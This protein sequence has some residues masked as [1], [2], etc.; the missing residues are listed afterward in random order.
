VLDYRTRPLRSVL[1]M[2]ASNAK[3]I[4]KA[5]S[6]ACDAVIL[7]LEDA[8]APSEKDSARSR[9]VGAVQ[10]GGFGYRQVV[11]RINGLDTPW[12]AADIAALAD[13]Q[14]DAILAPKVS[15]AD[16]V[17]RYDALMAPFPARTHLWIM[18]E[19]AR[20]IFRIEEIADA[21]SNTRL[22]AFV[23]GTNDICK[24]TNARMTNG[25][26]A[27]LPQL[28][29]SVSAA[30][31]AGLAIMDGVYNDLQDAAGLEEECCQGLE[32]GFDGKTLIHPSQIAIAN[33]AFSPTAAEIEFARLVITEFARPE[34]A[35]VGV[36]RV[37]G[38]MVERL[39]LQQCER[40]V[41]IT[42]ILTRNA[43]EAAMPGRQV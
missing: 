36:L 42:E 17:R 8:V 2:P 5:R 28:S 38:K 14:P 19:T 26:A 23:M 25:R 15:T 12:G 27:L 9:V 13:V 35:S 22:A 4:E 7:D 39:H 18:I 1:Y 30:R 33:E 21:A 41:A 40:L 37:D 6:L 16:D 11:V 34:N 24:E 43:Q 3:A 29:L 32:F 31:M 10:A 20:S